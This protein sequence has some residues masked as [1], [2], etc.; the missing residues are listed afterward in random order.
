MHVA[1]H[2]DE[3]SNAAEA[4]ATVLTENQGA[5]GLEYPPGIFWVDYQVC[6][7]E[8]APDHPL[9]LVAALPRDATV[10]RDHELRLRGLDKRIDG[11]CVARR[12]C[13]CNTAIGFRRQT[14]MGL[15]E[16]FRPRLTA[17]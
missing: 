8:G 4:L 9:A 13:E 11:L 14:L 3:A 10:V 16:L 15:R 12:I 5:V 6:K 2:A 7:V 1:M 17:I